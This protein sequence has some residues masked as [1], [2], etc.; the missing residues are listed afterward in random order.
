MIFL[1]LSVVAV[2][3]F[4]RLSAFRYLYIPLES[5]QR[6][7]KDETALKMVCRARCACAR[8]AEL[9]W[10][11][12]L[13][14]TVARMHTTPSPTDQRCD[15]PT[16][17]QQNNHE[18]DRTALCAI[19][20]LRVRCAVVHCHVASEFRTRELRRELRDLDDGLRSNIFNVHVIR[21]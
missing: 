9:S 10:V 21:V 11:L 2:A 4:F 14:P 3:H 1:F 18:C 16:A 6:S 17:E 15:T 7:R 19:K 12:T 8:R 13:S 5:I 20:A